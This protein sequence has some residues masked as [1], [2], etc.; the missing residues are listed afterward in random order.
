MAIAV[1]LACILGALFIN[2][3]T[4]GA[5]PLPLNQQQ[6]IIDTWRT[7][8]NRIRKE[9]SYFFSGQVGNDVLNEFDNYLVKMRGLGVNVDSPGGWNAIQGLRDPHKQR[10]DVIPEGVNGTTRADRHNPFKLPTQADQDYQAKRQQSSSSSSSSV[11]GTLSTVA[12]EDIIDEDIQRLWNSIHNNEEVA[13]NEKAL[14]QE[15]SEEG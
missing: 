14:L 8:L 3:N 12:D 15:D 13:K 7:A 2:N 4:V 10:W 6:P 1:V 9:H 11:F 5:K